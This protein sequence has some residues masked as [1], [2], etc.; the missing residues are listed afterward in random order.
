MNINDQLR[1]ALAKRILDETLP[2]SEIVGA[3]YREVTATMPQRWTGMTPRRF[4]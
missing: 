4:V 2:I 3:R 1:A